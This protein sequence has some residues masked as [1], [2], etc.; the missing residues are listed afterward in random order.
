MNERKRES[1][2]CILCVDK[3][4][5]SPQCPFLNVLSVFSI[6]ETTLKAR[7]KRNPGSTASPVRPR[8][9]ALVQL[10]LECNVPLFMGSER[11]N[12]RA[13]YADVIGVNP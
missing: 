13:N 9:L 10:A 11:R 2:N 3:I 5:S 12:P 4:D 7:K 1:A 8:S 6:S